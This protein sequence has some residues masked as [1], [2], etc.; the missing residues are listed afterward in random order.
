MIA[1]VSKDRTPSFS[2][3]WLPLLL[4]MVL[5][6]C[7]TGSRG[8]PIPYEVQNFG[9]PD[10]PSSEILAADYRIAPLDTLSVNVFQVPDLSG[11]FQ[12]D[13]TGQIAMPL[14]GTVRAVDLTTGELRETLV[15]R[16][17]ERYLRNPD[18]TVGIKA[19]TRR[20]ITVDGS[21]GRPGMFPVTGPTSLIQAIA[22]AGG[23]DTNA[24]P[25]RVAIFRQVDGQRMAAAFDLISI[26]RG[27]A[28]DPAV[29]SGDIIVVDGS[30]VA[31]QRR[32]LLQS[33]PI[34]ALF[35]PFF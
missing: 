13:L 10:P 19:S 7:G 12:V 1:C 3:I 2:W 21:V 8:G 5:P 6:G 27:E 11:D 25:R 23:P 28:E 31:A 29:Y 33:I 17:G 4:L 14:I 35:R 30:Q 18:V 34:L 16:L 32:E 20:N 26:R 24:N 9:P 22:M 15:T